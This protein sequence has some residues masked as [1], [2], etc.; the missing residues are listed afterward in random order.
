MQW[1]KKTILLNPIWIAEYF[2]SQQIRF[3]IAAISFKRNDK[4]LD[5]G[6]GLRP[7]E[8]SFP[9]GAYIGL[10][11]EV[12]GRDSNMKLADHY[13]DGK[14]LPFPEASFE[15]V[16]C[17]QV[18]EHVPN[19]QILLAE[20]YRVLK[21]E[22]RLIISLPFVWQEHEEPYDFFRFTR[23]GITALLT[24]IGY[25]VDSVIKDTGTIEALAITLNAYVICNLVPPLRFIWAL[26]SVGICFPIQVIALI[27]QRVLPDRGALY[28][29]MVI[30]AT[31]AEARL[32]KENEL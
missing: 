4:W 17:T 30:T 5:V 14:I 1:L 32:I 9:C 23:F 15:G 20:M 3:A 16:I 27:L 10:D 2:L 22:G 19:P 6:C 26:F 8:S 25:K 21:P 29:N 12:S 24:Q 7:Y 11:V 28:L 18:L 13:Y 31:K